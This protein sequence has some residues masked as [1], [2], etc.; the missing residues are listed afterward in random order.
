MIK[1]STYEELSASRLAPSQSKEAQRHPVSVILHNI[2][3]LYNVGS[4]FRT[5][6]AALASELILCGYT[7]CPPR[8]EIAKTA[9]GADETVPWR[10]YTNTADAIKEQK[11]LGK[12]VIAVE[13]TNKKRNYDTLISSDFPLCLVFGNELAGIGDEILEL[14]DDAVEIPMYGVKHSLN[15]AVA[16]GIVLFEAIRLSTRSIKI[17]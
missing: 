9:L 4:V 6:D 15:V 8:A 1:K 5:C 3:S 16:A 12:R 11:K 14:C 2:R 13:L 10:Y 7:P 17:T